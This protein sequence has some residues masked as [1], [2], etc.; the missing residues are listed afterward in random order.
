MQNKPEEVF[1]K[2]ISDGI[3]LIRNDQVIIHISRKALRQH[4]KKN[5]TGPRPKTFQSEGQNFK[6]ENLL[7][8]DNSPLG[9]ILSFGCQIKR[10]SGIMSTLDKKWMGKDIASGGGSGAIAFAL[11]PGQVMMTFA[12]LC[13]VIVVAFITLGVERL[14]AAFKKL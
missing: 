8:T 3:E 11:A 10:E 2:S 5:P 12:I 13:V 14:L 6:T 1:Y 4:F 7:V 9:P